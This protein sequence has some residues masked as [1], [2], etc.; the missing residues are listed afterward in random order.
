MRKAVVSLLVATLLAGAFASPVVAYSCDPGRSSNQTNYF[1]GSEETDFPN[2]TGI[3]ADV[4]ESDV[5]VDLF[6]NIHTSAWVMLNGAAG[7]LAQ[8]GWK[9]A[10]FNDRNVFVQLLHNGGYPITE[11][12]PETEDT[13]TDYQ[14]LYQGGQFRFYKDDNLIKVYTAQWDP[15]KSQIMGELKNLNNQMPGT[16]AHRQHF[17]NADRRSGT[18]TWTDFWGDNYGTSNNNYFGF[19]R[20]AGGHTEIWDK[21]CA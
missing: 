18:S 14:V 20:Y 13:Y 16:T 11:W 7:Q 4:Y 9:E 1:A 17:H 12:A 2:V 3:R 21:G 15:S 10:A 19:A 6:T 5:Y 8:V